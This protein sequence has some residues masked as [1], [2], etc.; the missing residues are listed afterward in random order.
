[1]AGVPQPGNGHEWNQ[2]RT[3][4]RLGQEVDKSLKLVICILPLSEI[5]AEFRSLGEHK[6]KIQRRLRLQGGHLAS[7][8][9]QMASYFLAHRRDFV[10]RPKESLESHAAE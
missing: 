9:N 8:I 1:M 4:L 10:M 5:A 3:E 2:I 7:E 6:L